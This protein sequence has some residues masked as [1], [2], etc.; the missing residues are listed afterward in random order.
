MHR[1][2]CFN[3]ESCRMKVVPRGNSLYSS[4]AECVSVLLQLQL[5]DYLPVKLQEK[6]K[7]RCPAKLGQGVTFHQVIP[8]QLGWS[9]GGLVQSVREELRHSR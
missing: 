5:L 2:E 1:L 6:L 7:L 3:R 4:D 8:R 9:S